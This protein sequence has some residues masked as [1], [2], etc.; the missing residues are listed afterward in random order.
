VEEPVA[1]ELP[2]EDCSSCP[3]KTCS[4]DKKKEMGVVLPNRAYPNKTAVIM[5]ASPGKHA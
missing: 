1:E 4:A 5:H 2:I 3:E